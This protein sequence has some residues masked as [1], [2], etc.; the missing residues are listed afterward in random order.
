MD[1]CNNC[2]SPTVCFSCFAGY[3]FSNNLCVAQCSVTLPFYYGTT[4]VASCFNGTYLMSDEI[5]CGACSTICS[6][7]SVIASNCTKCVGAYLYNFNCVSQCPNNYYADSNLVC[8]VCTASVA[9]CNVAPL[10]YTL[11]TFNE[12]G[13]LYGILT[14][15]R[16]VSMDT[17]QIQ[18]IINISIAG[19]AASQYTWSAS[20]INSTS[21]RININ[22]FVSLN[23]LSLTLTFINPSLVV[24]SAGSTLSTTTTSSPLPTYDYISPEVAAATQSVATLSTVLSWI[25][26]VIMIIL[27]FKGSY[28]LLLAAEVFQMVY[29]HYFVNETL[30][31]NFSNFLINLKYLN[32]Q[33]LPNP[34]QSTV[35]ANW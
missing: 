14:F 35:P 26:L 6:T 29:F 24:D 25:S 33:F 31:Y 30:P 19:L 17:T 1:G 12:N 28:A 16:A 23:E 11:N 4:C 18:N 21:Y 7:C 20:Q 13:N 2:T 10:T 15:N 32:F 9:Q 27:I 22:A 3:I 8:Q 34:L 5:T